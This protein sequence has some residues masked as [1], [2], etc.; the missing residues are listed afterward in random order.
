MDSIIWGD[1]D[2][3]ALNKAYDAGG[4]VPD[5]DAY[6]R[7]YAVDSARVREELPGPRD[8]AYGP[9]RDQL[10]DVFPAKTKG[11]PVILFIH[12]GYW[13]RLTKDENSFSAKALVPLGATVAVNTYS[14]CPHVHLDVIV[15]QCRDAV[16][17]VYRHAADWGA[18]PGKLYVMGHSAGGHLTGMMLGT[19][20]VGEYGLPGDVIK[21]GA[22]ISG[23]FDLRPVRR[24][25][26][27]EWLDLSEAGA[28]RNSP[29]FHLPP[30]NCPVI[31]SW[32]EKDPEGFHD[33]SRAYIAALEN[34]GNPLTEIVLPGLD[35]FAA[36][37]QLMDARSPLT[38][39]IAKMAGL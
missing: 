5:L 30:P 31:V 35:H 19:D 26:V 18:D 10:L 21:G 6:I 11:G 32:G 8:V 7:G 29:L 16:A 20:W 9:H 27:Q 2:Q 39:A 22:P 1:Y 25:H 38:Q 33:Q 17:H 13:R 4:S 37:N 12:G 36:G 34:N 15:R 14:L 23:L 3:A 24:S 28:E